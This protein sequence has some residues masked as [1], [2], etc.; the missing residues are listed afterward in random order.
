MKR[1]AYGYSNGLR[2]DNAFLISAIL[3][4]LKKSGPPALVMRGRSPCAGVFEKFRASG[5]T[6]LL[7]SSFYPVKGPLHR[8]FPSVVS[9][10]PVFLRHCGMPCLILSPIPA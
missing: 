9:L 10:L 3:Y 6:L 4:L 5:G 2:P 1:C 7:R 8:L